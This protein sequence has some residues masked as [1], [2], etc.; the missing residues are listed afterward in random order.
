MTGIE[1]TKSLK[2]LKLNNCDL[3]DLG[4]ASV[5]TAMT[6]NLTIKVFQNNF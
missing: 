2:E 6:K 1:G 4:G 3:R 5:A